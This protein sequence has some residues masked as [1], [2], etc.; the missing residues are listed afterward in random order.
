[1]GTRST[2]TVSSSGGG[3]PFEIAFSGLGETVVSNPLFP[4][5]RS[6]PTAFS[7]A[8]RKKQIPS[9]KA[10]DHKEKLKS[11]QKNMKTKQNNRNAVSTTG[12]AFASF[13]PTINL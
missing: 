10:D 13:T 4:A 2:A 11:T 7:G 9:N 8:S 5:L 1:V 3:V 6:S 12:T